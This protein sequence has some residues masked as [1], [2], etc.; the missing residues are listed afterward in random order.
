[1]GLEYKLS[2]IESEK[3]RLELSPRNHCRDYV[4]EK[5]GKAT[6]IAKEEFDSHCDNRE[7]S[8]GPFKDRFGDGYGEPYKP[9][10]QAF[11]TLK[12]GI[13]VYCE[14]SQAFKEKCKAL[15]RLSE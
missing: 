14:L 10:R 6:L 13:V 1:M 12:S 7:F 9:N 4:R 15:L 2:D 11:G 3:L 5:G 8:E